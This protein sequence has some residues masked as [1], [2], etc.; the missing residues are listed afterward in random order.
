ML[1]ISILSLNI[2]LNRNNVWRKPRLMSYYLP[3]Q[4]NEEI[5][6]SPNI[7]PKSYVTFINPHLM[8]RVVGKRKVI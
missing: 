5:V 1:I 3:M 2:E 4:V 7:A 8:T 6:S